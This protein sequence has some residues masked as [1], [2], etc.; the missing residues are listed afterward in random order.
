MPALPSRLR[1]GAQAPSWALRPWLRLPCGFRRRRSWG[2]L[3]LLY[4]RQQA[5]GPA[6][7]AVATRARG[8]RGRGPYLYI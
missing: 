8:R 5:D 6:R 4:W 2:G 7:A 3:G 1:G